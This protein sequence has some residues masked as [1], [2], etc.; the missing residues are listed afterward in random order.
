MYALHTE[1]VSE[2][3]AQHVDW[4]NTIRIDYIL[5]EKRDL[6]WG[7][8]S[9]IL[10]I[11]SCGGGWACCLSIDIWWVLS[12]P[13][14]GRLEH[15]LLEKLPCSLWSA[16]Y[17]LLGPSS[18]CEGVGPFQCLNLICVFWGKCAR[19]LYTAGLSL[20]LFGFFY[21]II[22]DLVS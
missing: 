7:N 18:A 5:S 4:K 1:R 21:G 13:R 22:I 14:E 9:G 12:L 6:H 8:T 17:S 20:M 19:A 11:N 2:C 10:P 15:F 3:T 16:E